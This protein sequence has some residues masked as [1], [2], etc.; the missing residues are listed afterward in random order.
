MA[1]AAQQRRARLWALAVLVLGLPSVAF[2]LSHVI[3]ERFK[4]RLPEWLDLVLAW[5]LVVPGLAPADRAERAAEHGT[6]GR[7]AVGGG[8]QRDNVG[9]HAEFGIGGPAVVIQQRLAVSRDDA[10]TEHGAA[11]VGRRPVLHRSP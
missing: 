10:D 6:D 2:A 7:P 9:S 5:T 1:D 4:L 8:Q 11:P 3:L